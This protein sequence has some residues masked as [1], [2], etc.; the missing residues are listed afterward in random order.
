MD[1]QRELD[2]TTITT[3]AIRT[4][5]IINIIDIIFTIII[6][7][8]INNYNYI[9]HVLRYQSKGSIFCLFYD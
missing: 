7:S 4:F 1:Q 5:N 9:D 6:N 3:T 2:K 8:I